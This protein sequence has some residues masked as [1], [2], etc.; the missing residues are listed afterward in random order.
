[1]KNRRKSQVDERARVQITRVI[2]AQP[3]NPQG[4]RRLQE[5]SAHRP[6][7]VS[8]TYVEDEDSMRRQDRLQKLE[9]DAR[10]R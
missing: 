6:F 8:S 3:Q 2:C 7:S 9:L 5:L 10:K 1:M 4:V